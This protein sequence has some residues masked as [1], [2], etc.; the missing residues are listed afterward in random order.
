MSFNPNDFFPYNEIRQVKVDGQDMV[1]IP[2]V[3]VKNVVL[4]DGPFR[5][6]PA[7]YMSKTPAKGYH[8]H[9]AFMNG[10]SAATALDLSCY[11]ASRDERNGN[12]PASVPTRSY[13][14]GVNRGQAIEFATRRNVSGGTVEQTGWHCWDIYCQSLL[15]RLMLF[16]YGTT[17][18]AFPDN[19]SPEY[20]YRGIHQPA[21]NPMRPTWLPGVGNVS[22][23][24]YIYDANGSGALINTGLTCPGKG[25]PTHFSMLKGESFDLGDVFIADAV[26]NN[27]HEG[28]CSDYQYL[29]NENVVEETYFTGYRGNWT[30]MPPNGHGMFCLMQHP[31][32]GGF[33]NAP[34]TCVYAASR[35][36]DNVGPID[37]P[38]RFRLARYVMG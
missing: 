15:A 3:Y 35:D 28:T 4:E 19:G 1:R 34:I 20:V 25:W 27:E 2:R 8:I 38:L 10:G 22:G 23:K 11:E 12:K 31:V 36:K 14:E 24:M 29:T 6:K 26:T 16:E 17:G 9:P 32:R 21:G 18:Y 37:G 7:Y 5:G 33:N 30:A 13:W